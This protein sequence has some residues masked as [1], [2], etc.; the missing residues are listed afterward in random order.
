MFEL[1]YILLN[2][3]LLLLPS[4]FSIGYSYKSISPIDEVF[5]L[6][7]IAIIVHIISLFF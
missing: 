4:I 7:L 5:I 3:I 1:H 2:F 6:G